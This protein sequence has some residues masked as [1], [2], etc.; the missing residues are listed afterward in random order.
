M[1]EQL[2]LK[3]VRTQIYRTILEDGLLDIMLGISLTLSGIF[4][5]N[6]SMIMNYIWLPIALVLIEVI[7]RKFIIPR[8]GYVKIKVSAF[9]IIRLLLAIVAAVS[10]ITA[11]LGLI[12]AGLN[13]KLA[14]NWR[15]LTSY[16]L[17]IF[18]P[19]FFCATAYK[20]NIQ[21][22]DLNGLLMGTVFFLAKVFDLPWLLIASGVV[23]SLIGVLVF[24]RYLRTYPSTPNNSEEKQ[25]H[26]AGEV[27]HAG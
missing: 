20:F 8:S 16:A 21:R 14:G 19:I 24:A 23:I 10:L 27:P 12:S 5:L 2:D 6:R 11:A 26:N 4:L 15:E 3:K 18:I 25:N 1:S 17:I 22:W 13:H 9:E 7:R